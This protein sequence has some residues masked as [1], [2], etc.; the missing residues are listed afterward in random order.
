[1]K[2]TG[3][4]NKADG[5]RARLVCFPDHSFTEYPEGHKKYISFG[6]MQGVH[7]GYKCSIRDAWY[8]VP[9]VWIPSAFFLRRNNLYPKFVLNRCG[10][11][12]TDTMHRMLF[13]PEIDDDDILLSYYNSIT[14]AFTEIC[15]RSYGGG[16][17]EI[18]PKEMGNIMI[19]RLQDMDTDLRDELLQ[20]VDRI[21][22]NNEDIEEALDIVDENVLIRCLG[23]PSSWCEQGRSIWKKM[24][25]RRLRRGARVLAK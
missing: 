19:P 5:K 23:I 14:F 18:L 21:V 13:N 10:A 22:R 3:K 17:L 8:I 1:M 24:Q 12:S 4:K 15:G 20:Q 11:V 9:S 16:V 25:N 2:V 7:L 6:E